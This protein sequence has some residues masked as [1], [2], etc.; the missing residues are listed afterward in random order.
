[1]ATLEFKL[2][3]Y[4]CNHANTYE[5]YLKITMKSIEYFT[6]GKLDTGQED[7]CDKYYLCS[8]FCRGTK[9]NKVLFQDLLA[10]RIV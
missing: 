8:G 9:P 5:R 10:F 2:N 1:M 7:F 3:Q 4:N 6:V